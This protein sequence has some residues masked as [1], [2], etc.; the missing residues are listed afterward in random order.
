MLL[1]PGPAAVAALV[2]YPRRGRELAERHADLAA[3][4]EPRVHLRKVV[5]L[6]RDGG[7]Q[8]RRRLGLPHGPPRVVVREEPR[9]VDV[10]V[11]RARGRR[12]HRRG[13]GRA[14]GAAVV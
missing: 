7:Q 4:W 1:L 2:Y 5:A 9:R 10:G 3:A 8:R 13:P 12:Q 11:G 6:V 14:D